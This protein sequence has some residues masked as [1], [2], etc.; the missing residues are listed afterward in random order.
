MAIAPGVAS[1]LSTTVIGLM[2]AIPALF[3]YNYLTGK[4]KGITAEMMITV[5]QF[6][7][8]VDELYGAAK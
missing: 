5:E 3:A 4:I 8:N 6:S 1:A 2:V 7:I